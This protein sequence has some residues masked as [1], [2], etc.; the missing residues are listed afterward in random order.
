MGKKKSLNRVLLLSEIILKFLLKKG[1]LKTAQKNLNLLFKNLFEKTKLGEYSIL[2][3][4]LDI[5][6]IRFE[7]RTV[8]KHRNFFLIPVPITRKRRYFLIIK[9]LFESIETNKQNISLVDKLMIE[10]LKCI[11][12]QEFEALKKKILI[13]KTALINRS[14]AHY[15]WY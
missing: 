2:N 14:N 7:I 3:K 5:L 10:I 13:E 12:N 4:I 9:W 11:K 8:K 6:Y 15:R 1:D